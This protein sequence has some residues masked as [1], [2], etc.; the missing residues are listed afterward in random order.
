MLT[1]PRS[2][3]RSS[4]LFK[5]QTPL[6]GSLLTVEASVNLS[7]LA[8]M[9]RSKTV[10]CVTPCVGMATTVLDPS[11]GKTVPTTT[12]TMELSVQSLMLTAEVAAQPTNVTTARSGASSGIPS[13]VM[14][15][16]T[17]VAASAH[18]TAS[19]A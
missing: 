10:F 4:R 5:I 19:G 17:S 7:T 11:A 2:K 18:P 3:T 6:A 1:R 13:A 15:T 12:V 9:I 8:K 16:T 14:D